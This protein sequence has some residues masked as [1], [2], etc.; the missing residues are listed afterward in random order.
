MDKTP[1]LSSVQKRKISNRRS[2][3]VVKE[4]LKT[5]VQRR[6]LRE[7][8]ESPVRKSSIDYRDDSVEGEF[9]IEP[10][11]DIDTAEEAF[12]GTEEDAKIDL[13]VSVP[14][15]DF[16][17][18]E[19]QRKGRGIDSADKERTLIAIVDQAKE[20]SDNL[21]NLRG[22]ISSPSVSDFTTGSKIDALTKEVNRIHNRF[23]E[24]LGSLGG[25][26]GL[27]YFENKREQD[28]ED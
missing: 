17:A 28:L 11:D 25:E 8:L 5:S 4:S 20:A 23:A 19:G 9:D 15:D 6:M 14:E 27:E 24:E 12:S 10:D 3:I 7:A 13:D 1:Y 26:E 22:L 2:R 18:K 21:I 16:D